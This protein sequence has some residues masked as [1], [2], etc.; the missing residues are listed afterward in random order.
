MTRHSLVAGGARPAD[1]PG[2]H[3]DDLSQARLA[4]LID[5]DN[6]HAAVIGGLLAE[7][8]R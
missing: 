8:A 3:N 2:D 5:A 4:V 7:V 6:A 1:G